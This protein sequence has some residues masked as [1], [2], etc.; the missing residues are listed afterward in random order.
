LGSSRPAA[1]PAPEKASSSADAGRGELEKVDP[2]QVPKEDSQPTSSKFVCDR[3]TADI[4]GMRM[5][6][7]VCPNFDYC[8]GCFTDAKII[9]PGHEFK[10]ILGREPA[11]A[12]NYDYKIRSDFA[13]MKGKHLPLLRRGNGDTKPEHSCRSCREVVEI[14][15]F[16]H[17]FIFRDEDAQTRIERAKVIPS[18]EKKW[19]VRITGLAEATALGCAF[20]S[21]FFKKLFGPENG[22]AFS[23]RPK[24]A[25]Y[26]SDAKENNDRD[27]ALKRAMEL[28]S[29]LINDR[30]VFK[31]TPVLKDGWRA[32]GPWLEKIVLKGVKALCDQKMIQECFGVRGAVEIELTAFAARDNLATQDVRVA[33][34]ATPDSEASMAHV[35]EWLD[36]CVS[37][38]GSSCSA[39]SSRMPTRV[40]DVSD[41]ATYRIVEPAF[42][43]EGKYCALSYQWGGAQEFHLSEAVLPGMKDGFLAESL[44]TTIADAAKVVRSMGLQYLWVDALCIIQDNDAD[45]VHEISHMENIYRQATVTIIAA[46][47]SSAKSGFLKPAMDAELGFWQSLVPL[48]YPLASSLGGS[49]QQDVGE[50]DNSSTAKVTWGEVL[51]MDDMEVMDYGVTKDPVTRRS[52]CLQERLVSPR[53]LNYGRWPTWRCNKAF[54]SDGGF[55]I[56]SDPT[57][58]KSDEFA[59]LL[60]TISKRNTENQLDHFVLNKLLRAWYGVVADFTA[61][62]LSDPLD[63]L[64][65]IEGI[66]NIISGISGLQYIAGLWKNN[67]LHDLMW[68][69][70]T[71]EWLMRPSVWRAPTW[72]WASIDYTISYGH[73]DEYAIPVAEVL[74]CSVERAPNGIHLAS[75]RLEIKGPM[76]KVTI[77]QLLK[78]F[79]S[80]DMKPAVA[81]KAKLVDFY[82]QMLE[83]MDDNR[84]EKNFSEEEVTESLHEEVTALATF[85]HSRRVIDAHVQNGTFYSGLLLRTVDDHFERIGSFKHETAEWLDLADDLWQQDTIVIH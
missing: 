65:A 11:P 8:P 27:K 1:T 3:C 4:D 50:D 76:R 81:K 38:H 84:N 10:A 46:S 2:A 18:I 47:S 72:S 17:L 54:F 7:N 64:P 79:K 33:P 19:T 6:C 20:C 15:A 61:R 57:I 14:F 68:Y 59:R 24:K 34:T 35:R 42:S 28:S 70:D 26:L 9:H 23:Y 22:L 40:V 69:A 5:K 53:V 82:R 29:K 66:A 44:P 83:Q 49:K 62:N 75:G 60:V 67:L 71:R 77:E 78:L 13:A 12:G 32:D 74:Q 52:W 43:Q 36:R 58:N 41:T 56:G 73:I 16:W 30:F 85:E 39:G 80:Q 63:R 31:I 45:K 48:R 21:Y 55:Y 37:N 51:F 25:W